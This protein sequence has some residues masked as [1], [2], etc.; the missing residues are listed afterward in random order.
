MSL[1]VTNVYD[2]HC[3]SL[4]SNHSGHSLFFIAKCGGGS[5]HT[6]NSLPCKDGKFQCAAGYER[7]DDADPCREK[8]A[9]GHK[10][11]NNKIDCEGKK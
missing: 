1:A 10:R 11:A 3:V 8:C 9:G 5:Q 7:V 2:C 4:H 6:D